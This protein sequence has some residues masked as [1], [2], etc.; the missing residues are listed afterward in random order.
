MKTNLSNQTL[1][2]L[3]KLST[4]SLAIAAMALVSAASSKADVVFD[5]LSNHEG[6][7]TNSVFTSTGSTPNTFMGDAYV[8]AAGTTDITG[9]DLL[10]VNV[11]GTSYTGLKI[12]IYVWGTVNTG[13]VNASTPAFS[14]LLGNYSVTSTGTFTSGFYYS[15]EGNP[16]GS[17]PGITLGTPL[18]ISSTTIGITLNIQGT[19]DGVTYNNVNN[20]SS[21]IQYGMA[22]TVGSQVFNGYYR[23]ANSEV[24]GNFTSTL[25]SLG[26]TNQS[27]GMR[28]F[29]DVTAVPEPTS[30]ALVGAGS[31]LLLLR[32]RRA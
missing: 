32:R 5:N 30:L 7:N 24:N 28:V 6:G 10:P 17:A 21:I 13:T 26:V 2:S 9:F 22:P 31:M 4:L 3:R 29:G 16:A 14:N 12:N 20:L 19:T 18:A 15:F 25:R 11:T 1:I 23:N 27:I 8:L